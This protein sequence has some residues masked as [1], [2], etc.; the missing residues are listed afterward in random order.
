LEF[1]LSFILFCF[2]H[3]L[4]CYCVSKVG[5]HFILHFFWLMFCSLYLLIIWHV[6]CHVQK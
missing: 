6:V 2:F 4:L 5:F 1:F 3:C